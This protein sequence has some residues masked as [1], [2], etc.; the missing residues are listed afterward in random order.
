M[1]HSTSNADENFTVI[2]IPLKKLLL[3]KHPFSSFERNC[4]YILTGLEVR[5]DFTFGIYSKIRANVVECL[6]HCN[7]IVPSFMCNL[8]S[9][10]F[11][12]LNQS[13]KS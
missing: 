8:H 13:S 5:I 3:V 10:L 2:K 12:W 7:V 6:R 4:T 1:S 11:P 9:F